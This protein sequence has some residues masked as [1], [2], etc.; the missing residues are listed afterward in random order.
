MT[1]IY[2]CSRPE[3]GS[4]YKEQNVAGPDLERVQVLDQQKCSRSRPR[5]GSFSKPG[6]VSWSKPGVGNWK[7]L[8]V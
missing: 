8:L 1:D 3:E 6:D 4:W 5:E 2:Y 7:R